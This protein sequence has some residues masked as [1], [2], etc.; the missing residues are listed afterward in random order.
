MKK[1]KARRPKLPVGPRLDQRVNAAEL[2]LR[3]RTTNLAAIAA[4]SE[5]LAANKASMLRNEQRRIEQLMGGR[6][7]HHPAIWAAATRVQKELGDL[8]KAAQKTKLKVIA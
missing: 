3:L 7:A 1:R 5:K 6:V 2:P 4:R 8:A